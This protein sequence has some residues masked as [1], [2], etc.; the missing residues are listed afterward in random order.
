MSE[1]KNCNLIPEGHSNIHCLWWKVKNNTLKEVIRSAI[2]RISFDIPDFK[3]KWSDVPE[4]KIDEWYDYVFGYDVTQWKPRADAHYMNHTNYIIEYRLRDKKLKINVTDKAK[5]YIIEQSYDEKK[6]F[7]IGK[8][9]CRRLCAFAHGSGP[10]G[11][12]HLAH[13]QCRFRGRSGPR[14]FVYDR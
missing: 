14:K 12:F 4:E 7:V 6:M 5:E 10:G 1:D 3:P 11:G 13:C 9:A 2:R 8:P